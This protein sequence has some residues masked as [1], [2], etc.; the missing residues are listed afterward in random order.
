MARKGVSSD[1]IAFYW[2]NKTTSQ[3]VSLYL[4]GDCVTGDYAYDTDKGCV[5]FF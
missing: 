3:L 4:S 2:G 5:V 1:Q